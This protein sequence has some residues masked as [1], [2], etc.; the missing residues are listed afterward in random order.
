MER[1]GHLHPVSLDDA[2]LSGGYSALAH[3]LDCQT[4]EE[5]IEELQRSGPE[6]LKATVTESGACRK[7]LAGPTY[8]VANGEEGAAGLFTDRHLMEGDPH[9]VL[10]GL[11]IA[12]Y[13]VGAHRALLHINGGARLPL[14]RM[15]RA[16]AK[17]QAAGLI[18]DRI[19]GSAFSLH[20]EIRRGARGFFRGQERAL[21]AS[22]EGQRAAQGTQP[23]LP[24][25]SRLWA[26]TAVVSNLENLAAVPPVIATHGGGGA[27]AGRSATRLF[28]VSGPVNRPGI[29]E[30]GRGVTLRTVLCE[31][32]AGLRDQHTL[33]GVRVAGRSDILLSPESL[34]T[35]L[36]SVDGLSTGTRGVIA[37]PD[38][39]WVTEIIGVGSLRRYLLRMQGSRRRVDADRHEPPN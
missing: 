32:A 15:A 5:V 24:S 16:L 22:I 7:G 17:A 39:D 11:L 34:D 1:C 20:V 28:G 13:A 4:P 18:G 9:R 30:V 12:A 37:I 36:E 10:E 14:Q 8:F 3:V 6:E 21:L 29:V 38:G 27:S 35:S 25:E 2:L 19:L 33:K 31:I 26:E 23:L